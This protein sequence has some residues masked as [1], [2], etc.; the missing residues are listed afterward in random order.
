MRNRI[1][2]SVAIGLGLAAA[3]GPSP[4]R[5]QGA[6]AF[7]PVVGAVPDGVS[8]AVTPAVS[9]DRRY[10][11]LS[12][13]FASNTVT[14]FST[15]NVPA[16]VGG[17]GA[18]F[19]GPG[20]LGG[21]G[22]L[23]GMNG[24]IGAGGNG[25]GGGAAVGGGFAPAGGLGLPGPFVAPAYAYGPAP[26]GRPLPRPMPR[27]KRLRLKAAQARAQAATKAPD[28]RASRTSP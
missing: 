20:A 28:A 14:G 11:R 12:V 25:G 1:M 3:F 21:L 19:N 4:A 9:A 8:L 27:T 23:A 2:G 15:F 16:A 17:G 5:G 13:G 7:Q 6:V 18:G 22:G 26:D 10:V 24:P